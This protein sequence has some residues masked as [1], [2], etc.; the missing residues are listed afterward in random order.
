MCHGKKTHVCEII[1]TNVNTKLLKKELF[2]FA[3]V[4]QIGFENVD[5]VALMDS[6]IKTKYEDSFIK[7]SLNA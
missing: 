6:L 5:G 7:K 3:E 4:D 2:K 1:R